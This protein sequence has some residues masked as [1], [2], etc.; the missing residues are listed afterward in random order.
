MFVHVNVPSEKSAPRPLCWAARMT[1]QGEGVSNP[2]LEGPPCTGSVLGTL[3]AALSVAA[4][5]AAIPHNPPFSGLDHLL[6]KQ[7]VAASKVA[8]VD[9]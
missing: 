6:T 2:K 9:M 5:L 3:L 8:V 7:P 4:L 1:S